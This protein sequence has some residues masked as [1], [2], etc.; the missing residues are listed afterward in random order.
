MLDLILKFLQEFVFF[1][2]VLL[3]MHYKIGLLPNHL[4]LVDLLV[5]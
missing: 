1:V 2:L 3:V 4:E 5:E